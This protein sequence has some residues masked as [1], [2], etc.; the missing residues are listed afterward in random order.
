M[1]KPQ[2]LTKPWLYRARTGHKFG[3][4]MMQVDRYTDKSFWLEGMR[5]PRQTEGQCTFEQFED[6]K[7]WL[8][9]W[10]EDNARSLRR[11]AEQFDELAAKAAA[12]HTIKVDNERY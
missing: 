2:K 7:R 12:I 11:S 9:K 10:S 6:A 1:T 5:C 3:I 8:I 4:T